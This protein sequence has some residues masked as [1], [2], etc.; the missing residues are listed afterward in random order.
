[1]CLLSFPENIMY[2]SLSI[3]VPVLIWPAR[4]MLYPS[5]LAIQSLNMLPDAAQMCSLRKPSPVFSDIALFQNTLTH[6]LSDIFNHR[7]GGIS[8][9]YPALFASTVNF[10]EISSLINRIM[11]SLKYEPCF[12]LLKKLSLE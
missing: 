4:T 10:P 8:F 3:D 11:N 12:V 5:F 1:M 9:I 6:Y 7:F 2:F